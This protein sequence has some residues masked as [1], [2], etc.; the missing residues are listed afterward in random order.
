MLNNITDSDALNSLHI[1]IGGSN[2]MDE[3]W[4][5]L[6]MLTLSAQPVKPTGMASR[7]PGLSVMS[8]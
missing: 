5:I 4:I 7:S 3:Y 6:I 1:R 2:L 8:H